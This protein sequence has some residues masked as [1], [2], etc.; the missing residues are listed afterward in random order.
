MV[1]NEEAFL[2]S[3]RLRD[4]LEDA[5]LA[6]NPEDFSGPDD[7]AIGQVLNDWRVVLARLH[8]VHNS[9]GRHTG[10]GTNLEE[11]VARLFSWRQAQ[12]VRA[13]RLKEKEA[14]D[15]EVEIPGDDEVEPAETAGSPPT[16]RRK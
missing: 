3:K 5:L 12:D 10:W 7:Q 1:R 6:G 16:R 11:Q 13:A 15:A 8:A 4:L 9:S 2:I 14:E